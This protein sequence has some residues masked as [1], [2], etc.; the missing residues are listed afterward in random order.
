VSRI[1]TTVLRTLIVLTALLLPR[2][3]HAQSSAATPAHDEH[4]GHV[5]QGDAVPQ[6]G[7]SAAAEHS[8]AALPPFIPV[9]T[10][11]D[12]RAAF[13]DP[14]GHPMSNPIR[15]FVLVERLEWQASEQGSDAGVDVVAWVG[16][17]RNRLWLRGEG[18]REDGRTE[19]AQ[20]HVLWGRQVTRWWDVVAGIR[21]DL[22]PGDAQTWAAVGVQGLAP[23]WFDIEA[24]GYVGAAG[25]T[26]LRVDADY[27]LLLTNRWIL[28]PRFEAQLAGKAD[29]ERQTAAGLMTTDV[30]L[31]LRYEIRRELAPYAGVMW[32]NKWQGTADLAEDAGESTSGARF[33]AGL[34]FW[35]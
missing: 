12:R 6:S 19:E 11:A 10:D 3:A 31:R 27:E 5:Q 18:S 29:V 2:I 30:G 20:A 15:T 25:R 14:G 34:R 1:L 32:R 23:Y 21:Q 13:P 16:R 35:W 22:D 9:L 26:Q 4:A 33:V 17:E 24:T 28:Q 7:Q 8:H